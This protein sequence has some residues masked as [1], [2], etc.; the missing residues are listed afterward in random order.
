MKDD[1]MNNE[2]K[3]DADITAKYEK[4]FNKKI[5]VWQLNEIKSIGFEMQRIDQKA[6]RY[7]KKNTGVK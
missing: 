2:N 1:L 7:N 6:M 3:I 5:K 4:D